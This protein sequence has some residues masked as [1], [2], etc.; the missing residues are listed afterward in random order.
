MIGELDGHIGPPEQGNEA[1]KLYR[2][3]LLTSLTG[4]RQCPP[5][6]SLPASSEEQP[7][8]VGERRYLFKVVDR[9][10][11]FSSS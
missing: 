8:A 3:S 5:D 2:G 7:I 10:A 9:P 4:T 6:S 11:F 1:V